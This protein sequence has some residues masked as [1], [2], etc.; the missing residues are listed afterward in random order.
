MKNFGCIVCNYELNYFLFYYMFYMYDNIFYI[1]YYL[2]EIEPFNNE[3]DTYCYEAPPEGYYLDQNDSFIKKCYHTCKT[4]NEKGDN[5]THNC[6]SCKEDFKFGFNIS[7]YLNCYNDCLFY[8]Y[9]DSNYEYLCTSNASCPQEYP[10][11]IPDKKECI[12]ETINESESIN[13]IDILHPSTILNKIESTENPKKIT[14]KIETT[15]I[16]TSIFENQ[17]YNNTSI[18]IFETLQNL[19]NEEKNNTKEKTLEEEIF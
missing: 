6:K 18:D 1:N 17:I 13:I 15:I 14:D 10:K 2:K 7:N 16:M 4:C 8:H 5:I 3:N 12:K 11:L 19:I 9:I